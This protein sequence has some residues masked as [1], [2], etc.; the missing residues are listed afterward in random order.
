[1]GGLRS[2]PLETRPVIYVEE[3][4]STM[5]FHPSGEEGHSGPPFSF[6]HVELSDS[7][8]A[9]I[10]AAAPSRKWQRLSAASADICWLY[11]Q[12]HPMII[13]TLKKH[14]ILWFTA[15]YVWVEYHDGSWIYRLLAVKYKGYNVNIINIIGIILRFY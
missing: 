6:G 7:P 14:F 3:Y 15:F 11:C 5:F 12:R 8:H 2:S 1:M 10:P 13:I 4:S 9:S